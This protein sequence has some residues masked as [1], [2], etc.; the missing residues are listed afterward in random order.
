MVS[1]CRCLR[2]IVAFSCTIGCVDYVERLE[3]RSVTIETTC[4]EEI[5]HVELQFGDHREYFGSVA[6]GGGTTHVD[7][8]YDVFLRDVD[9]RFRLG[10]QEHELPVSVLDAAPAPEKMTGHIDVVF[11]VLCSD[12]PT[13]DVSFWTF[14]RVDGKVTRVRIK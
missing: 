6:R 14:T 2:V 11:N 7:I 5:E 10:G 8:E 12:Q 1:K 4:Q 9:V 13:V 3:G